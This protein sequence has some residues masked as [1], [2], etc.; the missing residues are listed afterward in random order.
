M[1]ILRA[2]TFDSVLE[3]FARAVVPGFFG[4]IF[5]AAMTLSLSLGLLWS[6]A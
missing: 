3:P 6:L 2:V 1:A 4:W 5:F